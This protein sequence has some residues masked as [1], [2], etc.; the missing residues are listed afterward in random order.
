MLVQ[1]LQ[2]PLAPSFFVALLFLNAL[3]Q[4]LRE[5]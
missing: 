5:C 4:A 2:S 3:L 1:G